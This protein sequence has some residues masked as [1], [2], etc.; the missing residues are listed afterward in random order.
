[1]ELGRLLKILMWMSFVKWKP[2]DDGKYIIM[3]Q[4]KKEGK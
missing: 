4:A 1:M 3:V 2:K